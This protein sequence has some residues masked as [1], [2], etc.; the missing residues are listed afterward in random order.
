MAIHLLR[1]AMGIR[2]CL[3]NC[4]KIY[5]LFCIVYPDLFLAVSKI[6][7][8]V[9]SIAEQVLFFLNAKSL[10]FLTI[11]YVTKKLSRQDVL[12]TGREEVASRKIE[13]MEISLHEAR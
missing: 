8:R 13:D 4:Y 6:H 2:S 5:V 1:E 11:K 10:S 3:L 7:V 12:Y 9:H